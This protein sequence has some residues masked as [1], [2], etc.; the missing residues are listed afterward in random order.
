[1]LNQTPYLGN[2]PKSASLLQI[3]N[4]LD[5][6][7]HLQTRYRGKEKL[8]IRAKR[9]DCLLTSRGGDQQQQILC[10]HSNWEQAWLSFTRDCSI[11]QIEIWLWSL[12]MVGHTKENIMCQD[13]NHVVS[14]TCS[15]ALVVGTA[16]CRR[17]DDRISIMPPWV[18]PRGTWAVNCQYR[19]V[20]TLPGNTNANWFWKTNSITNNDR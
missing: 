15:W 14:S 6:H 17:L 12:L 11:M 8:L 16:Q 13:F 3:G 18:S 7:L 19:V 9:K 4:K 20:R 1:M 10:C 2:I 5:G